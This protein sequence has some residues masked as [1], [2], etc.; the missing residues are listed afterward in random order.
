MLQ[1]LHDAIGEALAT[2]QV[3]NQVSDQVAALLQALGAGF[4]QRSQPDSPRS[5]TQR[6]RL[7][8]KG[9]QWLG[10]QGLQTA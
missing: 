7:T 10:A 3:T 9:R 6:Y 1:A 4:I 8:L 5:P 2:D